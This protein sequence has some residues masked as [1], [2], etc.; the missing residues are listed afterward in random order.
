MLKSKKFNIIL[1]I[2]AAVALW[3][4]V[5]GDV[6]PDTTGTIRNVPVTFANEESL[7]AEGLTILSASATEVSIHVSGRRNDVNRA[8][9]SDF[10]VVCDVE[11]LRMGE[12]TVRL[13]VTGP[14]DIEIERLSDDRVTVNVD[15]LITA[16]KDIEV[17][18]SG[19]IGS[20]EEP[21]IVETS[22]SSVQVTGARTLVN[23][24]DRINATVQLS[25][26]SRE[27]KTLY[28]VL[29]PVDESGNEV[30]DVDLSQDRINV[31]AVMMMKKTVDLEV[32][33]TDLHGGGYERTV[34]APLTIVIKGTEEALAQ[35]DS[36]SCEP[37]DL[38]EVTEDA[39][40]AVEPILPEGIRVSSESEN[41]AVK[42]TVK[43]LTTATFSFDEG[44]IR[45]INGDGSYTY[46]LSPVEIQVEASGTQSVISELTAADFSLTVDAAN[47]TETGTMT[48]PVTVTCD[49]AVQVIE[50]SV[51]RVE[52]TIE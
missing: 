5:L 51:N 2:I 50:A 48:V 4:Y 34:D 42:V 36:I 28:A 52:I 26:I 30:P 22:S 44:D 46:I 12:T 17:V 27:M 20:D 39:T 33:I 1:A 35:V 9:A 8:E 29:T 41:L 21:Y 19:E 38:T 6:N 31:T 37:L 32:P 43:P 11:G 47:L 13:T 10:S 49:R 24:T 16:E 25:E 14:E 15:E 23:K 45:I 18:V 7:N 40:I 3:A